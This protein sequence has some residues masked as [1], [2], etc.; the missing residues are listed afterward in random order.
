MTTDAIATLTDAMQDYFAAVDIPEGV[1]SIL[2]RLEEDALLTRASGNREEMLAE[3]LDALE[4]DERLPGEFL[5]DVRRGELCPVLAVYP[6][7][8]EEGYLA[9]GDPIAFTVGP[10]G[11]RAAR[12]A[13][14]A[15]LADDLEVYDVI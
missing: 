9:E 10:D 15:T 5:L 8:E 6:E 12:A 4:R 7:P 1:D 2:V 14:A 11:L 13:V 3:C